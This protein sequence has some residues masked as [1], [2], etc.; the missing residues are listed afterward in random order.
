[1]LTESALE[2]IES[3]NCANFQ[4]ITIQLNASKVGTTIL[5]KDKVQD[6]INILLLEDKIEEQIDEQ[7]RKYYSLSKWNIP[8]L[9]VPNSNDIPDIESIYLA[10]YGI[11]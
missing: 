6:I 11:E 4:E 9:Q 10:D 8:A 5:G 1:M 3:E 2:Y 7:G